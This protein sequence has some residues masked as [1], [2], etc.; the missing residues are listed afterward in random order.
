MVVDGIATGEGEEWTDGAREGESE[1]GF[2]LAARIGVFCGIRG[3]PDLSG[4][5]ARACPGHPIFAL[6][7]G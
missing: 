7:L 5:R 3:G 2:E 4:E 6:Y 1:L